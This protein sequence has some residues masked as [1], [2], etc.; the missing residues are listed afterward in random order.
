MVLLWALVRLVMVELTVLSLIKQLKINR[1]I[2]RLATV[3]W[4]DQFLGSWRRAVIVDDIDVEL[5]LLSLIL[6]E[7]SEN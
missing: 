1:L 6:T 2:N 5:L 7:P 3:D 4:V